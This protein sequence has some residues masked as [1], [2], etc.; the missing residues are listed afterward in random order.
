M[1]RVVTTSEIMHMQILW[2]SFDVKKIA[3]GVKNMVK[4]HHN[5]KV[6]VVNDQILQDTENRGFQ[7][8]QSLQK[9]GIP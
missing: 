2:M 6:T 5:G 8:G 4:N 1:E 7:V 3:K 9:T